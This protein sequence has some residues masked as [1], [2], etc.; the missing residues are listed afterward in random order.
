M[1]PGFFAPAAAWLFTL[2]APLVLF[3]FLKLKRPRV[4]VPSL[5]L[6]RKVLNDSRVNSPF[7][8]FKKNLLLL[9]QL[10][11]LMLLVLAAMQPYLRGADDRAKRLPLLIDNSASMAALD[12]AGGKSRLDAVKDRVRKMIDEMLPD[13]EYSLIAFSHSARKLTG[14]TNNK[15]ELLDALERIKIEDV[16]S[17]LEEALRV[18]QALG[19]NTRFDSVMILSD[20]NFPAAV[21]FAL[22]YQV[23]Y[24]RIT[25]AGPNYGITA[26]TARRGGGTQWDVFAKIDAS[27]DASS[28]AA[29]ELIQDGKRVGVEDIILR[30]GASQRLVFRVDAPKMTS[31]ELRLR[32]DNFDSLASDNTAWI[33]LTPGRPL[34]VYCPAVMPAYRQ[35]LKS[36]PDIRVFPDGNDPGGGDYD[37]VISERSGDMNLRARTGLFIGFVPDDLATLVK[38]QAEACTVVDW[39]HTEPLLQHVELRDVLI[40]ERTQIQ[41][42]VTEGSFEKL[43]YE[44]MV[45]GPKGPLVVRR[46]EGP[47]L[48]YYVLFHTDRSTL[49][50]RVGFPIMVNNIVQIGMERAGLAERR[51]GTTGILAEIPAKVDATY[52]IRGPD[53]VTRQ[54]KA[55]TRGLL[56]GV[57]AP[58]AGKYKVSGNGIDTEIGASLLNERVTRLGSVERIQFQEIAIDAKKIDPKTDRSI[59]PTL[60]W[61]GLAVLLIEW[62]Y[63]QRRP[64]SRGGEPLPVGS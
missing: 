33:D 31:L 37:L 39:I 28:T 46:R 45:H 5:V 38:K 54:E 48:S 55:D 29:V 7:Q 30:G 32:T 18:A 27:P 3:Y 21:N 14:F 23:D 44:V 12:K 59:W 10:L 22:P 1:I 36:V 63:F 56:S 57:A 52:D 53:N 24:Q 16:P 11:L 25:G 49:P 20:G 47:K 64:R 8:R 61:L 15:R 17:D 6:W 40:A 13:Q 58:K 2:I 35:A 51:G 60:A 4:E 9:L 26:L 50:F 62:W 42:N 43:G 41:E 34:W 19:Q